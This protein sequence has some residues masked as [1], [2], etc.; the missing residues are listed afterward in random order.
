M[1]ANRRT[2]TTKKTISGRIVK[3]K[4][5]KSTATMTATTGD[6]QKAIK[7]LGSSI[8]ELASTMNSPKPDILNTQISKVTE[9]LFTICQLLRIDPAEITTRKMEINTLKYDEKECKEQKEI[10]KWTAFSE[11]TG[12]T[13]KTEMP[14]VYTEIT[15][16]T[17]ENARNQF[18]LAH[19]EIATKVKIFASKRNW[20]NKYNEYSLALSLFAELGE[21]A[22]VV[23]WDKQTTP[24]K[25]I[26]TKK[27]NNL[28]MELADIFIYI[29]H[30]RRVFDV[31]S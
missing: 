5:V 31:T 16:Q 13:E 11:K 19:V 27:M 23:Q 20:L 12:I 9:M 17:A 18:T 1:W 30:I 29:V 15:D 28:A 25:T 22:E 8:G 14:I 4:F 3:H 6:L 2:L 24:L 26:K 10:R 21:L 7:N